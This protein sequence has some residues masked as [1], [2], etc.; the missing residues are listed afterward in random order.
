MFNWSTHT[1][2]LALD[3]VFIALCIITSHKITASKWLFALFVLPGTALHELAHWL[4]ALLSNGRPR[5]PSLLPKFSTRR[6][7]LGEVVIANP[8]WYNRA[9]IALA[10]LLSLPLAWFCYWRWAHH[11]PV[12]DW[13]HW[14][15]LYV[16]AMALQGALPSREDI[17][18]A[19]RQLLAL[20]V[21]S[22]VG[23]VAVWQFAPQLVR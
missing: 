4:V 9:P 14:L 18:M 5:T 17:Q 13:R 20:L 16:V 7:T 1:T 12:A 2:L 15:L 21:L 11:L 22:V 23:A 3:A 6:W 19:W 8:T 10:P